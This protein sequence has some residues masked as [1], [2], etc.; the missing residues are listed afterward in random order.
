MLYDNFCIIREGKWYYQLFGENIHRNLRDIYSD[1]LLIAIDEWEQEY[2]LGSLTLNQY[3]SGRRAYV[4]LIEALKNVQLHIGAYDVM[5]QYIKAKRETSL[6]MKELVKELPKFTQ[7]SQCYNMINDLF[8]SIRD[9]DLR[10]NIEEDKKYIPLL[11][12]I[13]TKAQELEEEAISLLKSDYRELI[14]NRR[15]NPLKID[16]F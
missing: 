16:L 9:I 13:F 15:K 2:K 10:F 5:D 11:V 1:S 12:N 7:A 14:N 6:Y 8:Q 4:F 3:A